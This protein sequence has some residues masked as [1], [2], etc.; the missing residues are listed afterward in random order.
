MGSAAG[1]SDEVVV[2]RTDP[3]GERGARAEVMRQSWEVAYRNI[4]TGTEIGRI[5]DGSLRLAG[6]W[7]ARRTAAAETLV[8]VRGERLVGLAGLGIL[9]PGV[10]E[11]AA[12]YVHPEHQRRGVGLRLW[13]EALRTLCAHRCTRLEVW[14]LA[15]AE[16]LHFYEARGC[17]AVADGMLRVG[18]HAEPVIGYGLELPSPH[19]TED[20]D[21]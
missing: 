14:T 15:R 5:F 2:R 20:G 3:E 4:F 1:P 19:P 16:A 11:V 21:R 6:D 7:T 17:A 8:A 18:D 13:Q 12:F 9:E 10:G